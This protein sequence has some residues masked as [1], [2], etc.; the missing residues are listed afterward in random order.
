MLARAFLACFSYI[1]VAVL[2]PA[3]NALADFNVR[4]HTFAEDA[5]APEPLPKRV[6]SFYRVF[7]NK[8][9]GVPRGRLHLKAA[10]P[11]RK[12]DHHQLHG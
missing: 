6:Y 3:A 12:V 5:V 4:F 2:I 8:L 1:H 11:I 9:F 7:A 10:I